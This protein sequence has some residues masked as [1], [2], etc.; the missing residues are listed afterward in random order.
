MT[1][2]EW[3][4]LKMNIKLKL[5]TYFD[6][7]SNVKIV[8]CTYRFKAAKRFSVYIQQNTGLFQLIV[9][10]FNPVHVWPNHGL[11]HP[12]ILLVYAN[13]QLVVFVLL[14][15]EIHSHFVTMRG[16][17]AYSSQ[18]KLSKP[19]IFSYV[20]LRILRMFAGRFRPHIR[21]N[22]QRKCLENCR[23]LRALTVRAFIPSQSRFPIHLALQ[24]N[25]MVG[26]LENGRQSRLGGGVSKPCFA[27]RMGFSNW[28]AN[29]SVSQSPVIPEEPNGGETLAWVSVCPLNFS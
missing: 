3:W 13:V 23:P 19:E 22:M 8:D 6:E 21:V 9:G 28:C 10:L 29:G 20:C 5:L 18:H 2:S 7:L 26:L 16:T 27:L 17:F 25:T 4:I 14:N 1:F 11:E 12:A 15:K 24:R